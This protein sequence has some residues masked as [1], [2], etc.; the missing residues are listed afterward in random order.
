[1]MIRRQAGDNGPSGKKQRHVHDHQG[2][3]DVPGDDW[4]RATPDMAGP[5]QHPGR[6][7]SSTTAPDHMSSDAVDADARKSQPIGLD[8]LRRLIQAPTTHD[9]EGRDGAV[10]GVE[11]QVADR[12]QHHGE[13]R[14]PDQQDPHDAL[15]ARS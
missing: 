11:V 1:M 9:E 5:S 8:G 6:Q 2:D 15:A 7:R 10:V 13:P 4:S 12:T 14:E 3:H